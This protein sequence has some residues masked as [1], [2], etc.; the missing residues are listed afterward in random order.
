MMLS[1]S[2]PVLAYYKNDNGELVFK[3][4]EVN[5]MLDKIDK[6]ETRK[7]IIDKQKEKI[8]NLEEQL[9]QKDKKIAVLEGKNQDLNKE[10]NLLESKV[11]EV[12]FQLEKANE[13]LKLRKEQVDTLQKRESLS[14]T[15]ELKLLIALKAFSMVAN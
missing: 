8:S 2:S 5:T 3:P 4:E 6:S 9:K 11:Q 7:Q 1:I 12:E 13:Q 15:S 14:F 10:V